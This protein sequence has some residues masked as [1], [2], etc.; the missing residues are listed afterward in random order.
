ME[1][2]LYSVCH[3][4]LF[5]KEAMDAY[6]VWLNSCTGKS[7]CHFGMKEFG[8][9]DL[10]F[11]ITELYSSLGWEKVDLFNDPYR[12]Y[13]SLT[14]L[15][16]KECLDI[17]K[18]TIQTLINDPYFRM[19]MENWVREDEK[20]EVNLTEELDLLDAFAED[21]LPK[22][23]GFEY[24]MLDVQNPYLKE[25]AYCYE[26]QRA[27]EHLILHRISVMTEDPELK[28]FDLTSKSGKEHWEQALQELSTPFEE[29]YP[30]ELDL[31]NVEIEE[32]INLCFE[33]SKLQ[34]ERGFQY[35]E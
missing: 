18:K 28:D 4:L 26:Y 16:A 19:F 35:I 12:Y 14:E 32:K 3:E 11:W 23:P 31:L 27:K 21:F 15:T 8:I 30:S 10:D 29:G 22:L 25:R 5:C 2:K 6:Q 34:R 9:I 24:W 17:E 33:V 1:K 13:F 20:T 7:L